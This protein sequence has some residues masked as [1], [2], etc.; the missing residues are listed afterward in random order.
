MAASR[1][2]PYR[3]SKL[4]RILREAMGGNARTLMVACVAP[5]DVHADEAVNTLR[6]AQLARSI[7][8][9]RARGAVRLE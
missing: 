5:V 2:V 7:R 6:Y 8:C 4:T 9:G 3:A 1:H